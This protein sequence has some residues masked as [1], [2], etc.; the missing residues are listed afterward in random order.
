MCA[1]QAFA[2]QTK[3][4]STVIFQHTVYDVIRKTEFLETSNIVSMEKQRR[5]DEGVSLSVRATEY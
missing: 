2:I 3:V 4:I 5:N 1:F